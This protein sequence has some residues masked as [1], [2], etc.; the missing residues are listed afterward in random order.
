MGEG[1]N[2]SVPTVRQGA[3]GLLT[4]GAEIIVRH[5]HSAIGVEGNVCDLVNQEIV[6]WTLA[7]NPEVVHECLIGLPILERQLKAGVLRHARRLVFITGGFAGT[8]KALG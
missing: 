6:A 8:R 3:D 2:E 7:D 1:W 5:G 4:F